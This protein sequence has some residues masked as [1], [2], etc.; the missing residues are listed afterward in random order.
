VATGG[1]VVAIDIGRSSVRA[2]LHDLRA[3]PVPGVEVHLPHVARVRPDGTAE[4]DAAT[5]FALVS[6]AV[7]GVLTLA[8]PTKA[9]HPPAHRLPD[10]P[11][12]LQMMADAM[13]RKVVVGGPKEASSRG[14]AVFALEMLDLAKAE[15]LTPRQGRTFTPNKAATMAY[16]KAEKRQEALYEALI[17][18]GLPSWGL[19]ALGL[20][21]P[22]AQHLQ[23][24]ERN[25]GVLGQ[26]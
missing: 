22:L 23:Q 20:T 3:R 24:A 6:Q 10:P 25:L 2:I 16:K 7:S 4:V 17:L 21:D 14:A 15:H 9:K 13:G 8:G 11:K 19:V 26:E 18:D 12:R 1:Y 5:L